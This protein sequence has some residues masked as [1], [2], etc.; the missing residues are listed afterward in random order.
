MKLIP[1][2]VKNFMGRRHVR[3][4]KQ[5]PKGKRAKPAKKE[6]TKAASKISST[7][8]RVEVAHERYVVAFKIFQQK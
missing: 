2:E 5:S 1:I 7:T 8:K 6:R 3:L 4:H